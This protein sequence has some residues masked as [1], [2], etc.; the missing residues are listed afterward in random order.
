MPQTELPE[1]GE[2]KCALIRRLGLPFDAVS[3]RWEGDRVPL[4]AALIGSVRLLMAMDWELYWYEY[5]ADPAIPF[6]T[7]WNELKVLKYLRYTAF[8]NWHVLYR[9]G[10][11]GGCRHGRISPGNFR[12]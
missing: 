2:T 11:K 5:T 9:A 6:I 4:P 10:G 8:E 1:M 7:Y 3:L 12:R